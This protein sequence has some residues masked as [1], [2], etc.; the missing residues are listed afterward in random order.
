MRR[1]RLL[2][3]RKPGSLLDMNDKVSSAESNLSD[4]AYGFFVL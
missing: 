2:E 3:I 4:T 1:E